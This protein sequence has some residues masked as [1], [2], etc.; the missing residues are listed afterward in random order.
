MLQ[1]VVFLPQCDAMETRS[2]ENV[3]NSAEARL[4]SKIVSILI[5]GVSSVVTLAW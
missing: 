5:E 1:A 4:V 3:F 2:G